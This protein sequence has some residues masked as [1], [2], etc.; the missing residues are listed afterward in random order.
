[1]RPRTQSRAAASGDNWHVVIVAI[2]DRRSFVIRATVVTV[3]Q[4]A[5]HLTLSNFSSRL[6]SVVGRIGALSG[7]CPASE[8]ADGCRPAVAAEA[9]SVRDCGREYP[10]HAFDGPGDRNDDAE[11]ALLGHAMT[12]G[13]LHLHK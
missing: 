9:R 12:G 3:M 8:G 13:A 7:W 11:A 2:Q 10:H 1:M 6:H 4:L 5:R